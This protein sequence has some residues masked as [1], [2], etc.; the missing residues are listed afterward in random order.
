M[1]S[2]TC[3]NC[4]HLLQPNISNAVSRC[5]MAYFQ[6]PAPQRIQRPLSFYPVVASDHGCGKWQSQALTVLE[7]YMRERKHL[8]V[9]THFEASRHAIRDLETCA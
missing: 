7:K 5:G 8:P 1:E 9:S 3:K 2:K 4:S 6:Q